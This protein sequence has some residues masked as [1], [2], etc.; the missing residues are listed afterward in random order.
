MVVVNCPLV[1]LELLAAV[2]HGASEV[3]R[4]ASRHLR[5]VLLVC[6]VADG[7]SID[8]IIKLRDICFDCLLFNFFD[9]DDAHFLALRI[10]LS[11]DYLSFGVAVSLLVIVLSA[12]T[13][14]VKV[15]CK[16]GHLGS[17]G[18]AAEFLRLIQ[19]GHVALPG[20]RPQQLARLRTQIRFIL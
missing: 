16:S 1:K 10:D 12:N 13:R 11:V 7:P 15:R 19:M 20:K 5:L 9:T 18:D 2:L 17:L 8:I 4:R 3:V 6:H 14:R